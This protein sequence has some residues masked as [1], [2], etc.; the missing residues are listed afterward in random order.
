MRALSAL[1][2]LAPIPA[3]LLLLILAFRYA[4]H[5][6]P[7]VARPGAAPV[8]W[9]VP[10]TPAKP[11]YEELAAEFSREHP[12]IVLRLIW[13]PTSQYSTK[14]KTLAAAGEAP[15]LFDTGDVWVAYML[16]FLLDLSPYIQRDAAE[17]D[18]NDYLPEVLGAI[19]FDGRYY[20]LPHNMTVSLLYYNKA[21]FDKAG[22][23]YPTSEWTWDDVVAAGRRLTIRNAQGA[24][25]QWGCTSVQGWWGEWLT[26]V[27]QA[28]GQLF[29][30]N[31]RQCRLVSEES[32]RGMTFFYDK[33][34]RFGI[35]PPPGQEFPSGFAGGRYGMVVGGHVDE[36]KT[37]NSVAGLDWDIQVLPKGPAGRSGGE[38][39]LGAYGIS[40]R[41][42]H[43]EEAWTLLKFLTSRPAVEREVRRGG[44]AVRRSVAEAVLLAPG[45]TSAPRNIAAVYEQ[46]KY[47][48]PAPRLPDF[49]E[50]AVDVVQ[51]EVD[52]MM[53]GRQTPEQACRRAAE[54]ANAF[55]G[56]MAMRKSP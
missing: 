56:T 16:P 2:R 5:R 33:V 44:L 8:T 7:P 17:I 37:F 39:A 40:R 13:V 35:S 10:I 43:A 30:A 36:W 34:Y 12:E 46:L 1:A 52:L 55:L 21:L 27:R 48:V 26:Y 29:S 4:G 50:L 47:A 41:T 45:R 20:F 24:V 51:P 54:A 9:L 49:I 42:T 14:F 19:Q 25:V 28:G 38:V 22:L 23:A 53:Q 3:A 11:I 32:V 6:P 31:Q 18:L 15:D